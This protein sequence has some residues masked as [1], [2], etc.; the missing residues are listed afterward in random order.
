MSG[1]DGIEHFLIIQFHE[2]ESVLRIMKSVV[3]VSLIGRGS[4]IVKQNPCDP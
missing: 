1:I 2:Q 3:F 4:S